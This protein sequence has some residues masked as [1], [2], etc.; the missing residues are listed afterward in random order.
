MN[1]LKSNH[2]SR[3][4]RLGGCRTCSRKHH[5]L[6]HYKRQPQHECQS[7][8]SSTELVNLC[9]ADSSQ[10]D[11]VGSG[12]IP[13]RLSSLNLTQTDVLLSTA[14]VKLE[15]PNNNT[16]VCRVLL[17]SG[18]Q[19]NFITESLCE[20]LGLKMQNISLSIVGI[21]QITSNIKY[22]CIVTIQSLYSPFNKQ[23][24]CLVVPQISNYIPTELINDTVTKAK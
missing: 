23:I 16:C 9:R 10:D 8:R 18:S 11:Q 13:V 7:E 24:G 14:Q 17:D 21:T 22:K 2:I 20:K 19:S 12:N 3:Y 5:S 15:G 4:C 6:L 1:C